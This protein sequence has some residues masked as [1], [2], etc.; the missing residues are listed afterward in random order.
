[1]RRLVQV[2]DVELAPARPHASLVDARRLEAADPM[3][4]AALVKYM[5]PREK[6]FSTSVLKQALVRPEGVVG[7]VVGGFYTLLS[8][9]YPSRAFTGPDAAL[10]WL[11]QPE[12]EAAA[13]LAEL[14]GLVAEATGQS[15]L[16]RELHQV[17][18]AKLPEVNLSDVAREMGMSE[19]TLQRRLKEADTS[20]QAELNSVQVRMAQTLLR[21]SNMKLT[22]VAVEVG[23]A[24]LQH[25][26]SL[27]RKLVGESPSAWR[28]RQQQGGGAPASR[29]ASEEEVAAPPAEATAP[30]SRPPE[31]PE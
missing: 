13:L 25:F 4:F 28:D 21:E 27:F 11:G 29:A 8:G 15:P 5:Q 17:M 2:L 10:Q 18:R 24:S 7:A 31:V 26:S 30:V 16:L 1:M 9:A 14:N 20:F 22:A 19:R 12:A 23:C 3:A 6:A